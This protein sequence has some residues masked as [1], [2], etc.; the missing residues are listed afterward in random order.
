MK[1]KATTL[2]DSCDIV[3]TD[4]ANHA[5]G[6]RTGSNLDQPSNK[7][8]FQK[9]KAPPNSRDIVSGDDAPQPQ[10]AKRLKNIEAQRA[11]RSRREEL[12]SRANRHS[13]SETGAT[14]KSSAFRRIK[15]WS[16]TTWLLNMAALA[17]VVALI[18]TGF[19]AVRMYKLAIWTAQK[20]AVELCSNQQVC[21]SK[22]LYDHL[23]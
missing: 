20:D 23:C 19:F 10:S 8:R 13:Q 14:S 6:T 5:P 9:S 15:S 2:E 7:T 21:L 22:Q 1:S 17:G 18:I 16:W 11:F 4:A 3:S 12:R